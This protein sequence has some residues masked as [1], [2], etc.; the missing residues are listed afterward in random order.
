[1][2]LGTAT[3]GAQAGQSASAP[4]R[5]IRLSFAGD[6]SYPTG[7][8]LAFEAYVRAALGEFVTVLGVID[9]SVG[10]NELVFNPVTGNLLS[11]VKATGVERSAADDSGTQYDCLVV[12]Y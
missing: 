10:A 3:A 5:M 8:T 12:C 4:L 7:G 1:M 11:F 9:Q 2:A 6:D